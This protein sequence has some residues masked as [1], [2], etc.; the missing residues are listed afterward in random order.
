MTKDVAT[1]GRTLGF[2][3]RSFKGV[4]ISSTS[5]ELATMASATGILGIIC[6]S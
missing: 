5:F 1:R 6:H 2:S 4:P 3:M